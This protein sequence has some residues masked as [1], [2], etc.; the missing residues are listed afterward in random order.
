MYSKSFY[1]GRSMMQKNRRLLLLGFLPIIALACFLTGNTLVDSNASAHVWHDM[2]ADGIMDPEDVPIDGIQVCAT[3]NSKSDKESEADYC[4]YSDENGD[5]PSSEEVRGMFFAGANCQD[6]YIF[7]VLPEEY[8]LSTPGKVKGC[9]ASF[10][11]VP[12]TP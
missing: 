3:T 9:N 4:Y 6:I 1:Y 11:L 8:T 7:I 2:D 10:G 12:A 5:V